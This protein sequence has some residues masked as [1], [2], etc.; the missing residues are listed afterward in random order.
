M[1]RS[2]TWLELQR[3]KTCMHCTCMMTWMLIQHYH[4]PTQIP[5]TRVFLVPSAPSSDTVKSLILRYKLLVTFTGVL[6]CESCQLGA[7][8]R[9][10]RENLPDWH[11]S[12][13]PAKTQTALLF[14]PNITFKN[15][16]F[17]RVTT[18]PQDYLVCD[19]MRSD[20]ANL[21][22]WPALLLLVFTAAAV[23]SREGV[24]TFV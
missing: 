2:A 8:N 11:L 22:A 21:A 9:L 15:P 3:I 23:H 7:G 16:I 14:W 6:D 13:L 10:T 4:L 19:K 1:G 17:H 12:T 24:H 18:G 20:I 5:S